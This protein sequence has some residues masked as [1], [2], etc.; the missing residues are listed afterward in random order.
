MTARTITVLGAGILGLWQA[1][2][3]ARRGYRVRL[4]EA[5]ESGLR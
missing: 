2:T 1:Y 3:L 5:S 4:F